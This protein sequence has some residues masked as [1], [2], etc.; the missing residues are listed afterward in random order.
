MKSGWRALKVE[1][2]ELG[3]KWRMLWRLKDRIGRTGGRLDVEGG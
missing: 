2:R 3:G 1:W